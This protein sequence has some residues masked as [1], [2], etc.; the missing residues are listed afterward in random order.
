MNKF[1]YDDEVRL[2][3]QR[4]C[5]SASLLVKV[6]YL[7]GIEIL[8]LTAVLTVIWSVHKFNW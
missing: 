7:L 8:L 6:L 3:E 5:I 4:P 2:G 1:P